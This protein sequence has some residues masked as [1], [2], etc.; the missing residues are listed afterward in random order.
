M[1]NGDKFPGKAT[2]ASG[3]SVSGPIDLR[4]AVLVGFVLPAGW[5]AAAINL[6]VSLDDPASGSAPSNWYPLN[7]SYGLAVP[8]LSSPVALTAYALD[9]VTTMGW[10]FIRFRSGTSGAPVNQGAARDILT[11]SRYFG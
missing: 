6:E 8:Q 9:P 10:T 7:D 5:T 2:I 3:Q 11:T 1:L 4:K